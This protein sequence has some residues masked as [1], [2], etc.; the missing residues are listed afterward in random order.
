MPVLTLC[1]HK[2]GTG[3]TTATI[4][5]AA[6]FGLSGLKT[7]V[8]DLDPQSFLSEMLG[9]P[10]A[11][12]EST[13]LALFGMQPAL[14]SIPVQKTKY[15]DVLT[16]SRSLTKLLRHLTKPTDVFWIKETIESG[17]DYDLIIIDTAAAL[18]ALTFN[19]LVATDYVVI[20]VVPEYQSVIGADQ[21]WNTCMMVRKSLNPIL[22]TPRFLCSKVD[23]RRKT[24]ARFVQY[25]KN[26]HPNEVLKGLVRTD[27]I[28]SEKGQ[29]GGSIFE[30]NAQARGAVDFAFIAEE[31]MEIMGLRAEIQT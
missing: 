13:S 29:N 31:L 15:F 2:G 17:H 10:E 22:Q 12:D 28:L 20:P 11:K 25:L 30:V 26:H 27:T 9:L 19:A 8:I 6:A 21:T 1:N 4:N 18:T 5:L 3:K 23:A 16:S 24:H 7:L 14:K